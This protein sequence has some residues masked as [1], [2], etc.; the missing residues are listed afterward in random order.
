[1]AFITGV[2]S[3][4]F[5]TTV[6]PT[7]RAKARPRAESSSGK[8]NGDMTETTLRGWRTTML[9]L[10]FFSLLNVMLIMRAIYR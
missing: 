4:G 7:A 2:S 3:E 10:P 1:M 5:S 9:T 6:L 8:F